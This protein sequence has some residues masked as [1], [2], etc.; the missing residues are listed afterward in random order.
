MNRV[1]NCARVRRHYHDLAYCFTVDLH[2][3]CCLVTNCCCA[4]SFAFHYYI[5]YQQPPFEADTEDDLFES[6]LHDPVL[7]P[8]WL[9]K[10]ATS[11]IMGV[12]FRMNEF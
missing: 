9:T 3:Q 8:R 7:Y 1:Q 2:D 4:S 6:I 5:A 12:S 10:E 11:V